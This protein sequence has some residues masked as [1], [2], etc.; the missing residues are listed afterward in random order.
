MRNAVHCHRATQILTLFV[1]FHNGCLSFMWVKCVIYLCDRFK[2][3]EPDEARLLL[4]YLSY[5]SYW[6][7]G[8]RA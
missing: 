8:L 3:Q 7:I 1:I 6:V 4:F 2:K 5:N